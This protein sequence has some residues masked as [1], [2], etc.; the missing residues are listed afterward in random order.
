M[1]ADPADQVA[2]AWIIG[3]AHPV[4]LAKLGVSARRDY[5]LFAGE[6]CLITDTRRRGA[7]VSYLKLMPIRLH[8]PVFILAPVSIAT[9]EATARSADRVQDSLSW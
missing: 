1:A 5:R 9:D 7:S 3:P 4:S 6:I 8:A 2:L